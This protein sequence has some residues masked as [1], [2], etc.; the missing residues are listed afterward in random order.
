[1]TARARL[2]LAAALLPTLWL[3]APAEAG[4]DQRALIRQLDREIVALQQRIRLLEDQVFACAGEGPPPAIYAE[5]R[6]VFADGPV[7][8][9][10]RAALVL[11]TIP[12]DVLFSGDGLQIREEAISSLDLLAT[13]LK[14]HPVQAT[15]TAHSDTLSPPL[16]LR[17]TWPTARDWTAARALA[18]THLLE[19]RFA[20]P[21]ARLT[22]AAAGANALIA[23]ED[24]PEGRA[25]NRRIVV[26]IR[27]LPAPG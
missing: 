13:A 6:Q 9:E 24:T 3:A 1:M 8:V 17:R 5:L 4:R 2:L 23:N 27:P 14:L 12:M 18:A 26:E 22:A 19:D 15:L 20:V 11:V 21:P 10:R 25:Q 16:A 7:Q